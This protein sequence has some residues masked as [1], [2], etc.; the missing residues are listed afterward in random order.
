MPFPFHQPIYFFGVHI[1]FC[2]NW[3][4]KNDFFYLW[5]SWICK[6]V[7]AIIWCEVYS[8]LVYYLI[9]CQR[10]IGL[11]ILS[12]L[13]LKKKKYKTNSKQKK[14]KSQWLIWRTFSEVIYLSV[15][16]CK[17]W[18]NPW[19]I[20]EEVNHMLICTVLLKT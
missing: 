11:R 1:V 18:S 15:F 7:A 16:I 14:T 17:N 19:C 10:W 8:V 12:D 2:M 20:T 5:Q 9:K 6:W 3:I 13:I 4:S